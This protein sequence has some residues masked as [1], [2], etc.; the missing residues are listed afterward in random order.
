MFMAVNQ[1]PDLNRFF[2]LMLGFFSVSIVLHD[3]LY[4]HIGFGFLLA[5]HFSHVVAVTLVNVR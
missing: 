2:D 4:P 1:L 3:A 5:V